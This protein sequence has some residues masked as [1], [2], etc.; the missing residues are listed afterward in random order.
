[1]C[2][3]K[4]ELISEGE[5]TGS[6]KDSGLRLF[7]LADG[8]IIVASGKC[9]EIIAESGGLPE[10]FYDLETVSFG[11]DGLAYLFG[12]NAEDGH[13]FPMSNQNG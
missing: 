1:M 8:M 12:E 13:W 9:A 10:H 7:K 11:E 5:I 4:T 2:E 3:V 6:Q